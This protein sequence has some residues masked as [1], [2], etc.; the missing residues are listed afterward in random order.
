MHELLSVLALVTA[1]AAG[2]RSSWSPC[3]RSMLS[4]IT[5]LGERGRGS[6]YRASAGWFMV[7]AL[8][9]GAC[10]GVVLLGLAAAVAAS[11]ISG[12]A[13]AG[14]ALAAALTAVASDSALVDFELPIHRRQVNELWLDRFRPWVYGAGFGWQIGTGYGTYIVGA[15]LYLTTVLAVL[16]GIPLLALGSGLAFGVVRG[17][18][19]LAGRHITSPAALVG[20]H[21]RFDAAER[22]VGVAVAGWEMVTVALVLGALVWMSAGAVAGVVA[23]ALALWGAPEVMRRTAGRR[24]GAESGGKQE[25]GA[26]PVPARPPV[27]LANDERA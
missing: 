11:G 27:A 22:P 21:R 6:S 12:T 19:V 10:L 3:G 16:G 14:L 9:G 8:A 24:S 13:A 26:Q 1:V 7:G 23:T 18:A 2:I 5:P 4:T 17:L 15:T 25:P 20:F